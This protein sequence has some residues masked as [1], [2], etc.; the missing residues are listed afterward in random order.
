MTIRLGVFDS[1]MGG[2]TVLRR[3]REAFPRLDMVYLGDVARVPYGGRS[4]ETI[5]RYAR[6]DVEFLLRREVDA[7]VIACGT[8]SSNSLDMLR[9]RFELPIYGVIDSAAA[10]AA[11][12]TKKGS[13]GIIGT[14]ATVGSGAFERAVRA[15]REDVR[16][17]ACACPL[18]VP[19][20]ENGI[21]ADDPVA[22]EICRRYLKSFEGKDIDTLIL[23][24]THYPIYRPAFERILPGVEMIDV[25]RALACDL[26]AQF[27][28]EQGAGTT[29]YYVT[30]HSAAFDELVR[31]MDPTVDPAAV[32]VARLTD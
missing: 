13:V 18:I 9:E 5:D 25:G 14:R 1:G 8:V 24:C 2:L 10:L 6:E 27:G 4:R 16:V 11:R 30:E 3:L 23:G 31:V 12:T 21:S 32:R 15:C 17:S 20:V 29:E 7:V 26:A 22:E 28:G 19:L